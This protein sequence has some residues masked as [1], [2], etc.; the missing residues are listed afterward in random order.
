MRKK[1]SKEERET[2]AVNPAKETEKKKKE[3]YLSS[4]NHIINER[5]KK[6][7][8]RTSE[9]AGRRKMGVRKGRGNQRGA[10]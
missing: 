1:V 8:K 9:E 7:R 4:Q 5:Q 2:S 10:L 3:K 6:V